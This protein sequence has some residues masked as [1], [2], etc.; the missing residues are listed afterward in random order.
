MSGGEINDENVA[1]IIVVSEGKP[2]CGSKLYELKGHEEF[3][4]NQNIFDTGN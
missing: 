4:R 3:V 2:Y 1:S